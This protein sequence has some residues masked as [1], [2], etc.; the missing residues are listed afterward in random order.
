M[1]TTAVFISFVALS[2][3]FHAGRVV[4]RPRTAAPGRA[5]CV[6]LAADDGATVI[7]VDVPLAELANERL[8]RIVRLE[9]TD[10]ETNEL[11]WRCL[12]YARR[13]DG[14]WDASSAF[15]KFRDAYPRPPDLLGVTRTYEKAVDEP[16]LRANQAL[17]RSI[18]TAHKQGLK[19]QL[20]PLGFSGFKL[21]GLTP[22]MT[23]RAQV[24]N[25]LIYYRDALHGRTYD[26]IRR[27]KEELRAREEA[28]K[29]A[30]NARAPTGL[31]AQHVM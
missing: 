30:G 9:T 6:A 1:A 15:S 13:A 27:A 22:N 31:T 17:A 25:W 12:G 11:A 23:R 21:A 3:A 19:E 10:A 24:V 8:L 7:G 2:S 29:A 4:V 20:T 5:A 14:T 28:D 16:V 18:P 26:E